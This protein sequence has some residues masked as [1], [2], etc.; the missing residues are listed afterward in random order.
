MEQRTREHKLFIV[1]GRPRKYP[2]TPQQEKFKRAIEFCG[3]RKG[4]TREE[5]LKA[6]KECLPNY[7]K[8]QRGEHEEGG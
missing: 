3:I 5:L 1:R 4:M 8:E 2:M 6:M 7:F